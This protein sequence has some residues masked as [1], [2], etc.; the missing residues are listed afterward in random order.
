MNVP[1]WVLW[2]ELIFIVYWPSW[3]VPLYVLIRKKH[4][5]KKLIFLVAAMLLCFSLQYLL[6]FSLGEVFFNSGNSKIEKFAYDNLAI[7]DNSIFVI[8]FLIPMLLMHLCAKT[9]LFNR[10]NASSGAQGACAH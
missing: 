9:K 5:K 2:K 8:Q 4:L 6:E 7:I 10:T 3:V 1:I